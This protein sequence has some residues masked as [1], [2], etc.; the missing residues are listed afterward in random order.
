[1][2]ALKTTSFDIDI[3]IIIINSSNN[4]ES[5][6]KYMCTQQPVCGMDE[7]RNKI[8]EEESD[9]KCNIFG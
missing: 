2:L 6:P 8:M 1:M 9:A 7:K 5:R 3:I 4:V